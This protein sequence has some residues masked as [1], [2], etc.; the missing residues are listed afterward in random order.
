[1]CWHFV[2]WGQRYSAVYKTKPHIKKLFF[3]LNETFTSL[4]GLSC[5]YKI[6]SYL[7][8]ECS[9][10]LYEALCSFDIFLKITEFSR[11]VPTM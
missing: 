6:D 1:M 8:L 2:G 3:E 5:M 7:C 4:T 11:N 9:S 10:I